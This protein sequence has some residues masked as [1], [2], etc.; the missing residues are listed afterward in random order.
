MLLFKNLSVQFPAPPSGWSPPPVPS[1]ASMGICTHMHIHARMHARTHARTYM[2][3]KQSTKGSRTLLSTP[4]SKAAVC[5]ESG[6]FLPTLDSLLPSST[7]PGVLGFVFVACSVSG[8]SVHVCST[9]CWDGLAGDVYMYVLGL[10]SSGQVSPS[11]TFVCSTRG[12]CSG[13]RWVH[14]KHWVVCLFNFC[15]F[16]ASGSLAHVCT[17]LFCGPEHFEM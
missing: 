13:T 2:D 1:L 9:R 17:Y 4:P 8:L 11:H 5:L 16:P 12:I 6:F 7:G 15:P 10:F 3:L 14:L